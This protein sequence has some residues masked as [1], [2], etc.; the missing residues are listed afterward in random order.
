MENSEGQA[1]MGTRLDKII[2]GHSPQD[3][4][5][6]EA[7]LTGKLAV[8]AGS[9]GPGNLQS[10]QRA[11]RSHRAR[12]PVRDIVA[13]FVRSIEEM[14]HLIISYVDYLMSVHVGI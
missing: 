11:H 13:R 7:H 9:D 6:A 14:T 3:A 1:V 2:I 10:D 12:V 4:A 5:V 8:C